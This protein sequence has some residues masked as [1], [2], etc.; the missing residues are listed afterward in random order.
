MV[1]KPEIRFEFLLIQI[2]MYKHLSERKDKLDEDYIKVHS[3]I[4][5]IHGAK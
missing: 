5:T 3:V 2:D 1:K 4:K